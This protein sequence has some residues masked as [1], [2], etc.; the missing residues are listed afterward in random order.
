MKHKFLDKKI[1]TLIGILIIIVGIGLTTYLVKGDSI[2]ELQASPRQ[3]PENIKITNVTESSFTVSYSTD[4]SALGT[5]NYGENPAS[6]NNL[7]LDDRDQLT[8]KVSAR[9]SHSITVKNLKED[10]NYFFSITSGD[11]SYLNKGSAYEIKTGKA[12]DKN[13]SSQIPISGKVLLPEGL[14][15][16][17]G[18]VYVKILG[19]QDLSTYIKNDGTYTIPLNSLRNSPLDDFYSIDEDDLINIE[20]IS[21]N[22]V[23]DVIVT[24]SQINPVPTISLSG[25][26][27]FS[28]DTTQ[29]EETEAATESS[30]T[31]PAFGVK[32]DV[33]EPEITNPNDGEEFASQLPK[34]TGTAQPNETVEIEIHSDENIT[35]E[36]MADED[37]NW[38]YT[39]SSFLSEGEHTI[40]ITTV[41][42]LGIIQKITKTFEIPKAQGQAVTN[43]PTPTPNGSPTPTLTP[44]NTPTITPV[45][46]ATITPPTTLLAAGNSSVAIAAIIG[47]IASAS[48]IILY[49]YSRGRKSI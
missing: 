46:T 36:V 24:K 40:T 41:N 16:V 49:L 47:I 12:I 33:I 42:N 17:D 6:L 21:G 1:P 10:T 15:A 31:F 39:P 30:G 9:N 45:I 7:V 22:F 37:G 11:E 34:F 2:F 14:P 8:Q 23:S 43:T 27:D 26:Y 20:I 18:L 19:A 44:T 38:E 32:Q 48:G 5:L 3:N 4:D 28:E 35:D 13:P 29:L 25:N